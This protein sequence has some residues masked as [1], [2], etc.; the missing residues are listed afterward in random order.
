MKKIAGATTVFSLETKGAAVG[1]LGGDLLGKEGGWAA[2]RSVRGRGWGGYRLCLVS[3][4]GWVGGESG[5]EADQRKRG[6]CG[7]VC[8]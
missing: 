6:S 5:S 4:N 3:E 1:L 8:D 7:R 2:N